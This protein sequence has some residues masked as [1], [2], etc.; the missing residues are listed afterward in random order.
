MVLGV[1]IMG[2]SSSS[3]AIGMW[4]CISDRRVWFLAVFERVFDLVFDLVSLLSF[5]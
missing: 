1:V 5:L 3:K 2:E 4:V